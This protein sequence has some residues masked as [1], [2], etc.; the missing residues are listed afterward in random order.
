MRKKFSIIIPLII[1][2]VVLFTLLVPTPFKPSVWSIIREKQTQKQLDKSTEPVY[3]ETK[4]ELYNG[5]P[6]QT[7]FTVYKG[8]INAYHIG[9]YYQVSSR[10]KI[11]YDS[12]GPSKEELALLQN[13]IDGKEC[14]KTDQSASYC[15]LAKTTQA[16]QREFVAVWHDNTALVTELTTIYYKDGISNNPYHL[17][18]KRMGQ[19]DIDGMLKIMTDVKPVD[20]KT[21]KTNYFKPI[22]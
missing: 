4:P 1:A 19:K 6:F 15:S 11:S 16:N 21:A 13:I 10:S 22:Y 17:N 9:S 12:E 8:W 18:Y 7:T 3:I 14:T 20:I 5:K 2:L